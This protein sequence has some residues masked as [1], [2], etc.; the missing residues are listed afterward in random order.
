MGEYYEWSDPLVMEEFFNSLGP[1]PIVN[2]TF[3]YIPTSSTY[4]HQPPVLQHLHLVMPIETFDQVS[5]PDS[6]PAWSASSN[7]TEA[8]HSRIVSS[9]N[10]PSSTHSIPDQKKRVSLHYSSLFN[11]VC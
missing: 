6:V 3:N 1:V 9:V 5:A 4:H 2:Q 8:S 11:A 7:D 10:T